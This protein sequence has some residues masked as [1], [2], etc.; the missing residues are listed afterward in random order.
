MLLPKG[1][2]NKPTGALISL[3][4]QLHNFTDDKT[5]DELKLPNFRY[6]EI[7]ASSFKDKLIH[8]L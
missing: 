5:E 8:L 7:M 3:M 2:L 1:N 6:R 4:N